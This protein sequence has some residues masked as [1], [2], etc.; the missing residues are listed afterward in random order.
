MSSQ[1]KVKYYEAGAI[2]RWLDWLPSQE[3]FNK[4]TWENLGKPVKRFKV[5]A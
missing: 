1:E 5:Y 4:A 3:K 2:H